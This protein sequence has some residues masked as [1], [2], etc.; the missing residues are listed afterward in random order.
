[1][2][3]IY[4]LSQDVSPFQQRVANLEMELG[5]IFSYRS[6]CVSSY[7]LDTMGLR[8]RIV[9]ENHL[10]AYMSKQIPV[11]YRA[12]NH[13]ESDTGWRSLHLPFGLLPEGTGGFFLTLYPGL[14]LYQVFSPSTSQ[15]NRY[16]AEFTQDNYTVIDTA[17]SKAANIA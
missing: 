13:T 15:S 9:S 5:Y 17:C 8:G 14:H 16:D 12:G 6:T 2:V 10:A 1:M 3:I 4:F 7:S 11:A